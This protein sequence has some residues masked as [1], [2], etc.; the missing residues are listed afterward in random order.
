MSSF[1]SI[2]QAADGREKMVSRELKE[3]LKDLLL[4]ASCV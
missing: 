3:V 2:G 1:P 4:A